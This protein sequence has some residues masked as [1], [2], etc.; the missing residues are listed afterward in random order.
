MEYIEVLLKNPLTSLFV[1]IFTGLFLGSIKIRGITLG[2]TGVLISALFLGKF[3][4][5]IPD[6]VQ[7]LGLVLFIYCVGIQSGPGFIKIFKKESRYLII[8]GLSIILS[9]VF[10]VLAFKKVFGFSSPAAAGIF[11]GAFNNNSAL[12]TVLETCDNNSQLLVAYGLAYTLCCVILVFTIQ[13][14]PKFLKI[15]LYK[16]AE[17][18]K[19]KK[20][21][22]A[23]KQN[24]LVKK[25]SVENPRVFEKT[26]KELDIRTSTGA[27]ISRV[28]H[29]DKIY[30][31]APDTKLYAGDIVVAVGQKDA[32]EKVNILIGPESFTSTEDPKHLEA[33]QL[34]LTNNDLHGKRLE[35]LGASSRFGIVV[36]RI[37]RNDLEFSPKPDFILEAGDSILAVGE[38]DSL[39]KFT[40]FVGRQEKSIEEIDFLS[41]AFGIFL[42]IVLGKVNFSNPLGGH[43][44]LG[45]AGGPLIVGL[46]LG[47][48]KRIG[49]LTSRMSPASRNILREFGL[50]LFIAGIGTKIGSNLHVI[51]ADQF[52]QFVFTGIAANTVAASVCF[53]ICYKAY[54]MNVLQALG[55]ICGALTNTAA[56]GSLMYIVDSDEPTQSYALVYPISLIMVI[57]TGQ[58][59]VRLA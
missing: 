14:I 52:L 31:A 43:F 55:A 47:Y 54:K 6:I 50:I 42:G 57:I 45:Y 34:I 17:K 18:I 33:R 10:A 27:V 19:I 56:L 38:K 7:L 59:L 51:N 26:I 39:A 24:L 44:Q 53:I 12:A 2:P 9:A 20:A 40:Q 49:F 36:T 22:E 32:L 29:N 3:G 37:W 30:P 13:V 41:L 1:I 11:M 28:R 8:L 23:A 25:F 16:E 58:I 5:Q 48:F 46:I 21:D 35:S 15:N 4:Y